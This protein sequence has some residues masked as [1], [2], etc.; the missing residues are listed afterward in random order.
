MTTDPDRTAFHITRRQA[1]LLLA[2]GLAGACSARA[3]T[4]ADIVARSQLSGGDPTRLRR[5][6]DKATRGLPVTIG[7]FG[8]SITTGSLASNPAE[9]G[10]AGRLA[11]WWR[12]RFP[13]C[14]LKLVNAGVAGTGSL[15]GAMRIEQD[16]LVHRPDLVIVEFAVNDTWVDQPPYE[17][18][19]RRILAASGAPAVMLL[20]MMLQGGKGEQAWQQK[21]GAHY[22]LPMVSYRDALW[23]EIEAGRVPWSEYMVDIAHPNDAGHAAAASF[24]TTALERAMAAQGAG[25]AD[26][27]LPPPLFSASF[28]STTWRP[29]TTLSPRVGPGWRLGTNDNISPLLIGQPVWLGGPGAGPIA[30]EVQGAGLVL[31]LMRRPGDQGRIQVMVDGAPTF[32]FAADSQPKRDIA[33][34][35]EK[36]PPGRHNVSV[37]TANASEGFGIFGAGGFGTAA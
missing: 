6:F 25:G 14:E 27:P 28:Q 4:P 1:G 9:N 19:V 18:V 23:P 12:N 24:L 31:F 7:V 20:F 5:V 15:Y 13:K 3:S 37:T 29:A 10:Y 16:L 11:A 36:L 35:A 17:G 22:A 33:I 26:R 34:I 21:I 32:A 2:G 30:F 8:G